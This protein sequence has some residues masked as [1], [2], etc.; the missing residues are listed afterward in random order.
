L[1][2]TR[3]VKALALQALGREADALAVLETALEGAEPGGYRRVFLDEG[4]PMARL[5]R[6]S[7]E[8]GVAPAKPFLCLPPAQ[9]AEETEGGLLDPLSARELDV[10]RLMATS[11]TT[12]Q[13]AEEL[14]VSVNTVRTHVQHIYQKLD[15]H[16]R[17]EAVT[18]ARELGLL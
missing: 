5:L 18:R 1:V 6:L 15:A 10:L 12:P 17:Y 13:M 2:Q 4:E 8:R 14:V 16:S 3:I 11:L 7:A 9:I